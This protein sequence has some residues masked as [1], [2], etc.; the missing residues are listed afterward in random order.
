MDVIVVVGGREYLRPRRLGR[1]IVREVLERVVPGIRVPSFS[2][3]SN[4]ED[5]YLDEWL[6]AGANELTHRLGLVMQYVRETRPARGT[7]ALIL[8]V[9]SAASEAIHEPLAAQVLEA[10]QRDLAPGSL[11]C[12]N[13]SLSRTADETL[14]GAAALT[15]SMPERPVMSPVPVRRTHLDDLLGSAWDGRDDAIANYNRA[16]LRHAEALIPGRTVFGS[17]Y[18]SERVAM[19]LERDGLFIRPEA[20]PEDV[21]AQISPGGELFALLSK[22]SSTA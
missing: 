9:E 2:W 10:V 21:I 14:L 4:A 15:G 20:R 16:V 1:K 18:R 22:P 5:P 19:F 11:K 3:M 8:P 7:V 6:P 13:V 17:R 12:L